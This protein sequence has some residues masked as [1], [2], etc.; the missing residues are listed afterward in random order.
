MDMVSRRGKTSWWFWCI[1]GL[2]VGLTTATAWGAS[3]KTTVDLQHGESE[4]P[5]RYHRPRAAQLYR[6]DKT[7]LDQA[8]PLPQQPSTASS[9]GQRP[10]TLTEPL[11]STKPAQEVAP[12]GGR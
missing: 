8:T 3:D 7:E 9:P 6:Y 5:S 10:A 2:L 1:G 4:A 11:P 12:G